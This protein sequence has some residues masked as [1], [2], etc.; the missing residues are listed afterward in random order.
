ADARPKLRTM[1]IPTTSITMRVR[2]AERASPM[3]LAALWFGIQSVWG[4]VLG[5]SLQARCL[6][7]AGDH[8]LAA[9]GQIS[10]AGAV[11][12]AIAQLLAG[13]ISDA[14]R[15]AGDRRILFYALGVGVAAV[16]I[17][18]FYHAPNVA[19]LLVWFVILQF[20]LNVAIGPY[21]AI[22]PDAVEPRRIGVASGWLAGMQSAGNA[23]GAILASL[24]LRPMLLAFALTIVLIAACAITIGH[25]RTIALQ[26]LRSAARLT[27]SKM[28]VDLFISRSLV[29]VGFYTLLGYLYFYVHNLLPGNFPIGV[30]LASGICIL[31]FTLL[32]IAG[33]ALAAGPSD[34]VDERRIVTI[35]G[36]IV[37]IAVATLA[38]A[39]VIP[40]L[41]LAIA[42]AGTGWGIF[43]CADWAFAC[44]MLPP[45][46]LATTMAVWNLAVVGPQIL[47]PLFASVLLMRT[48]TL[49]ALNGPRIAFCLA[50]LEIACG[51]AWIWRLPASQAGHKA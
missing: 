4:A 32:G 18:A 17:P 11:A 27:L 46:A 33:A 42:I 48:G 36:G 14:R 2:I 39:S 3:R 28:L 38:V 45:G 35:G 21:Q 49:T 22:V 19:M 5:I 31:T 44:R 9:Y 47:A 25:L 51:I 6:A 8:A 24:L 13:P 34:F 10:I 43:L 23:T 16:A 40:A 7:L 29:Y 37:A 1:P 26:P 20:G 41:P 30:R 50:A 12:A 15:R